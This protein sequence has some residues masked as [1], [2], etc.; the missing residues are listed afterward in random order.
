MR[1]QGRITRWKD[2]QGYGFISPNVGGEEV[3]LHIKAFK[4]RQLRPVGDETVTYELVS[5][6][7]GRPRAAAVAFVNGAGRRTMAGAGGPSRFPLLVVALF[8]AFFGVSTAAGRLP[9]VLLGFYAFVSLIAFAAYALDKSAARSGRWRTAEST[10]HLLSLVGGWPGALVAQNRLRHKSRKA[11]F[12]VAFWATVMLN[13]GFLGWLLT[14]RGG[15]VLRMV[16]GN[17]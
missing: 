7:S 15:H 2:D 16:L 8:F 13:C 12:L 9:L 14:A 10:L 17:T 1:H 4:P 3:F 6:A 11:S 5:D